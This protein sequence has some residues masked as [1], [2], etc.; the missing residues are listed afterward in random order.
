MK[1]GFDASKL[2]PEDFQKFEETRTIKD[3]KRIEHKFSYRLEGIE[4]T[5]TY[6]DADVLVLRYRIIPDSG[7]KP[8]K[9]WI[10]VSRTIDKKTGMA[11]WRITDV[12][13]LLK[14]N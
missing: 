13:H 8:F 3:I 4:P 10:T 12:Q 11:T 5:R 14:K 1:L 7:E 2:T 6:S 9:V